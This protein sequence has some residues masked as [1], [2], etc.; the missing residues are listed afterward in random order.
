MRSTGGDWKKRERKIAVYVFAKRKE[1]MERQLE[2]N[3]DMAIDAY[4]EV[5]EYPRKLQKKTKRVGFFVF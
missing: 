1:I 2:W 4:E 5:R 3:E